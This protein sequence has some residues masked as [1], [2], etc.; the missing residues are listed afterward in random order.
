MATRRQK[1]N[2]LFDIIGIREGDYEDRV[3][4][5]MEEYGLEAIVPGICIKDGCDGQADYEPDAETD[6][7][8]FA[9]TAVRSGLALLLV[10]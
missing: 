5:F 10:I 4:D 3:D 9:G 2:Q 8:Q 6:T 7:A 1:L